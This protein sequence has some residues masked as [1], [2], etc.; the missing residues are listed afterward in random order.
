MIHRSELA[1]TPTNSPLLQTK[2]V[3]AGH[4]FDWVDTLLLKTP[5]FRANT[6]V[7]MPPNHVLKA[8]YCSLGFELNRVRTMHM[9]HGHY[10]SIF[11]LITW[12]SN[13]QNGITNLR[14][15]VLGTEF[16]DMSTGDLRIMFSSVRYTTTEDTYVGMRIELIEMEE[17]LTEPTIFIRR[18]G[19]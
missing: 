5:F 10:G 6:Q 2:L 9:A 14:I 15:V 12:C 4:A 19:F 18:S 11:D 7:P 16:H 8:M 1:T 3:A 17:V 13:N